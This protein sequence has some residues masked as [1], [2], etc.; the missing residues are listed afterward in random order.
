MTLEQL[1][2]NE[3]AQK[4][5][6]FE[7]S[8]YQLGRVIVEHRERYTIQTPKSIYQAEITGNLRYSAESKTDLPAVGDWV[9]LSVFD[10][11]AAII[12]EVLPRFSILERQ[13]VGKFGEKQIIASNVD[14]AFIM[15]SVGHDFNLNRLERYLAICTSAAIQPVIILSKADLASEKELQDLTHSIK[16]RIPDATIYPISNQTLFGYEEL[17]KIITEGNT[18]CILGSS[19]VG[20]SSLTNNLLQAT[21]MEVKTVSKSNSK[22][23]HTTSHRELIVL[24][25]GGIIIDTPGMRELGMAGDSED[26]DH[27]FNQIS[28]LAKHCRFSDCRHIEEPGCAVLEALESGELDQASYENYH[29]LKREQAHFSSTFAERRA[30]DKQLG[31]LYK[32]IQEEK[33]KRR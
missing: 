12:I 17:K 8:D 22:G 9:K 3:A 31:K 24:P 27:T 7:E 23:R 18:Y 4:V 26:I 10:D 15:Q 11:D 5:I 20:K 21:K 6:S 32:R 29:K 19:G 28:R 33:N 25:E 16:A 2:Y 13:A 1:G 30:K 14:V